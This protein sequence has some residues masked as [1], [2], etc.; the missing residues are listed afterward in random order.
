MESIIARGRPRKESG[1]GVTV[2]V[3]IKLPEQVYIRC[4]QIAK[5]LGVTEPEAIRKMLDVALKAV[6]LTQPKK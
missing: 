2:R 1:G 4:A 6:D 3:N 5:E